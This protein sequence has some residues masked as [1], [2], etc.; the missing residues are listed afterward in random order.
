MPVVYRYFIRCD[1][2]EIPQN[3]KNFREIFPCLV[4]KIFKYQQTY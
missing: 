2:M 1:F 4:V 3:N